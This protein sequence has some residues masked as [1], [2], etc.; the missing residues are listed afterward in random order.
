MSLPSRLL[1]EPVI[2]FIVAGAL[3][4]LAALFFRGDELLPEDEALIHID[5]EALLNFMQFRANAFDAE[6]FGR[7]L[8]NM[9]EEE[10]DFLIEEYLTEEVLYRE[11]Q[12][13]NLEQSDYIIRQ[14]MV[15]KMQFLLTDLAGGESAFTEEELNSYFAANQLAWEVLPSATFTHVFFDSTRRGDS[16]AFNAAESLR[17]DFNSRSVGF[18]DIDGE[19]DRFP[20]LKNHVERTFEYVQ[21]QFGP[22]FVEQLATLEASAQWQG[23]LQSVFGWHIVLLTETLPARIPELEEVR[24]QVEADYVRERSD[25]LL[26]EM[27]ESVKARYSTKLAPLGE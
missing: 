6:A 17:Q 18:N 19:G 4:Y 15:Q 16:D 1:R 14:R 24:E 8:D 7:T 10:L 11:A 3:L 13:L 23:P 27:I 25:T 5:R 26:Q 20:F 2:H 22:Q 12:A 9:S 21:G